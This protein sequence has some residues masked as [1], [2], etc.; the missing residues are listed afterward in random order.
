MPFSSTLKII[1]FWRNLDQH[2]SRYSVITKNIIFRQVIQYCQEITC[3]KPRPARRQFACFLRLRAPAGASS[4]RPFRVYFA[5]ALRLR[6]PAGAGG[7]IHCV[8]FCVRLRVREFEAVSYMNIYFKTPKLEGAHHR[9][10]K[11][12]THTAGTRKH[13]K[14]N[15]ILPRN[16]ITNLLSENNTW[17]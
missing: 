15:K 6:A 2:I 1:C 5:S 3:Q 11:I 13:R 10:D 14:Q 7:C 4:L 16:M 9:R 17:V 8:A 12:R